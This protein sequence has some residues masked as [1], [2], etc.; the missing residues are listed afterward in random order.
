MS[1]CEP[2][3]AMETLDHRRRRAGGTGE[4]SSTGEADLHPDYKTALGQTPMSFAPET[5]QSRTRPGPPDFSPGT[6]EQGMATSP[7]GIVAP[8]HSNRVRTEVD[9]LR[10][11][12]ATLDEDAK[13]AGVAVERAQQDRTGSKLG[14]RNLPRRWANHQ[15][16]AR[17]STA[18]RRSS[19][20]IGGAKW[21]GID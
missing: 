21:R 17:D 5:P 8:F 1:S 14:K 4:A 18:E 3:K 6:L 11:R 15:G 7:W 10:Y 9:L 20:R 19:W 12:P 16:I 13:R 2:Q